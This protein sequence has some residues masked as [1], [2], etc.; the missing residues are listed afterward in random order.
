MARNSVFAF[1]RP[2]HYPRK[3]GRMALVGC[4]FCR[5]LFPE[6]ESEHCPVCG[7]ALRP[8]EKLPPSYEARVAMAAELAQI[9]PEDRTLSL[10]YWKRGRAALAVIAV[11]G[12]V[13]FFQPWVMLTLPDVQSDSRTRGRLDRYG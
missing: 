1:V 10:F 9:A 8:V 6:E 11:L 13:A 5:E 12:L 4:P 2:R 7:M 3:F